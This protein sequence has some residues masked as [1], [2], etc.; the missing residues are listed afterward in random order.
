MFAMKFH[1]VIVDLMSMEQR[2][3]LV[4]MGE[5]LPVAGKLAPCRFLSLSQ[6]LFGRLPVEANVDLARSLI[7]PQLSDIDFSCKKTPGARFDA[8]RPM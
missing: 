3:V 2:R 5:D 7:D 8:V 4:G 1:D 6:N